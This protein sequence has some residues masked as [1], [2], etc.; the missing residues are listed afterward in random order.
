MAEVD[1]LN[2]DGKKVAKINLSDRIFRVPVISAVLHD[3]VRMQLAC[4]RSGT[5]SVKHRSDVAGSQRK[6]FRQKGT[7][8]ARRGN[9]KSP[10]LRGGGV[11]FGP[12]PKSY[13]YKITRKVRVLGLKMALSSKLKDNHL[14]ILEHL[15]N[16][17][18][19]TK[20]FQAIIDILGINNALLITEETDMNL[21]LACRNIPSIKVLNTNGLNVY[22]ILKFKHLILFKAVIKGIEGRLIV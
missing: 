9:I 8:K 1:V 20:D 18:I 3:V 19:K 4:R 2:I 7:G 6:L 12:I 22:D 14:L 16:K 15:E 17:R 13:S 21:R 10:L 11:V 5:A